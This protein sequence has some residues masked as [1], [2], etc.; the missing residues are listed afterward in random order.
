MNLSVA[1]VCVTVRTIFLLL[2]ENTKFK[3]LLSFA[4]SQ[5]ITFENLDFRPYE[6]DYTYTV[7]ENHLIGSIVT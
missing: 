2:F 4:I 6:D 1:F 3:I 5:S 7:V